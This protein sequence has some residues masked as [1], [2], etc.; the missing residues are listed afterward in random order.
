MTPFA[1][2]KYRCALLMVKITLSLCRK[3]SEE[4]IEMKQLFHYHQRKRARPCM[5]N[6]LLNEKNKDSEFQI[7][8]IKIF[9]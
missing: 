3:F 6:R 8:L 9:V 1:F 5:T 7:T 2:Y 4:K